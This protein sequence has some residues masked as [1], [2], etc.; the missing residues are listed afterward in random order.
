V[1]LVAGG[2]VWQRASARRRERQ[3]EAQVADRTHELGE[4]VKELDCLYGISSL[5]SQAGIS[6]EEILQGTVALLPPALQDPEVACARLVLAGQ[7]FKTDN[8]QE[9]PWQQSTAI[10]VHGE[11]VGQVEVGY[12]EERPE[13]YE[14]PLPK[15]EQLLLSAVAERVGRIAE[16]KRAEDAL[17][18]AFGAAERA[19]RLEEARRQEAERRR[20]IA[21][22]L[23]DVVAALNSD[24]ALGEVL[25]LIAR[26]T[27][28]LLG[29][30]AVL[31]GEL[32]AATG[33]ISVLASHGLPTG[34][35]A[36]GILPPSAEVLARAVA[37]ARPVVVPDVTAALFQAGQGVDASWAD[38]YR[39]LAAVPILVE[40]Q[41]YGGLLLYY[42]RPRLLSPEETE[43]ADVLGD[44]V[45]LAMGNARLRAEVEQ[46]AVTA[47]RNKIAGELHD[48]VTQALYT[49]SLIAETLPGVWRRQPEEAL[50]SLDDL[51]DLTQ[52]ALAEMRA[53]LLELR[54]GALAGRR[55][56]ELLHQLTAAMSARTDL[57]ITTTVSG[58][59][60]LPE[61]VK[62]ALYRIAQ[63]ALNNVSK[64]A[65]ASRAW[66]NLQIGPN[67]ATLRIRD[68]GRG[69][70]PATVL[71]HALGLNIMRERAEAIGANFSI[72]SQPGQGTE[73]VVAWATDSAAETDGMKDEGRRASGPALT[74]DEGG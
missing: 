72:D 28:R 73:V 42:S 34:P 6:L 30:D 68:N 21:E 3:L 13:A 36:E 41:M 48:S 31:I 8:F 29:A 5:A 53:L 54:P 59:A 19:R 45:A 65:R 26:E 70:E 2:F 55:L 20:Q 12:L 24:E 43:L 60:V 39:V 71:P 57:P 69:F 10:L 15:Q 66:V 11:Q 22:V 51:R 14:G 64:H 9:T 32:E 50:R 1:G 37:S 56:S 18:Q 23:G 63:E 58:D 33:A 4:R 74:D 38:G 35:M 27:G 7:E 49:S 16:R 44:H 52:G 17:Q 46:A 61:R 67:E 25:D 62:I 47:E 40:D